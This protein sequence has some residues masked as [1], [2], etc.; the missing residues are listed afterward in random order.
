MDIKMVN[1]LIIKKDGGRIVIG[2]KSIIVE[3]F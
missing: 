3:S 2:H 1:N